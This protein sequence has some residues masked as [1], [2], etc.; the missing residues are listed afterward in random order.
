VTELSDEVLMAYADG[1][2]DAVAAEEVEIALI[3]HPDYRQRV[4]IF[5]M[6]RHP[7]QRA[8]DDVMNEPVPERAV[9]ILA[10]NLTSRF[11]DLGLGTLR[12][13]KRRSR[14]RL[15]EIAIAIAAQMSR[16]ARTRGEKVS[17]RF[18]Q[19]KQAHARAQSPTRTL[20]R[21]F[22]LPGRRQL[23]NQRRAA[24]RQIDANGTLRLRR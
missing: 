13:L 14:Q 23:L 4:H 19:V 1:V 9:A 3:R 5:R 2:L 16:Y 18:P 15:S 7:V 10:G 8:F 6:T 12:A 22:P 21:P 17:V 24:R 20:R 11:G